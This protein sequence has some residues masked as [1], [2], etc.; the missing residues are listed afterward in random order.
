MARKK[1]VTVGKSILAGANEA[2]AFAKGEADETKYHIH[3]APEK[4]DVKAIR[5]RQNLSQSK[6]AGR[7]SFSAATIR[8]WEQGR[9]NPDRYARMLLKVI[10]EEPEA[11][12]RALST[13][14]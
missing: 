5:S 12:E 6:F 14:D 4:V 11:V 7:Y 2:L 3:H 8:D 1:N 10:D 13:A 9:R